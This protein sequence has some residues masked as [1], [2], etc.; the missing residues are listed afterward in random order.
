[1]RIF[2]GFFFRF[3]FGKLI[4]YILDFILESFIFF[5]VF[6][7]CYDSIQIKVEKFVFLFL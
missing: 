3:Q 1:M 4:V 2:V 6:R 7:V 5:K